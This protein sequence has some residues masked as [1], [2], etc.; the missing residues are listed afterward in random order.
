MSHASGS[1]EGMDALG[2]AVLSAEQIAMAT[3]LPAAGRTVA[4]IARVPGTSRPAVYRALESGS[5]P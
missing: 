3:D 4:E 1:R 2:E 5:A